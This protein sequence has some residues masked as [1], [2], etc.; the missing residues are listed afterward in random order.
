V[1]LTSPVNI[2]FSDRVAVYTSSA[3]Q[4]SIPFQT[5]YTSSLYYSTDV[6]DNISFNESQTITVDQL[7]WSR[8]F[9]K[10]IVFCHTPGLRPNSAV[11]RSNSSKIKYI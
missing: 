8:S 3:R 10:H 11:T 4:L 9:R 5:D 7:R 6:F 1:P 2:T